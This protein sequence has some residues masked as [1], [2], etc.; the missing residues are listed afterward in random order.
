MH[1]TMKMVTRLE[2]LDYPTECEN[3]PMRKILFIMNP[4]E[5]A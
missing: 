2:F 4:A 3:P 1:M 5:G